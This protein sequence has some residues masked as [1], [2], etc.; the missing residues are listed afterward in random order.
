MAP[1][2]R[3]IESL[4]ERFNASAEVKRAA[5]QNAEKLVIKVMDDLGPT[6]AA[7]ASVAQFFISQGRNFAEVSFCISQVHP[8]MDRLGDLLLE[9]YPETTGEIKLLVG[10]RNRPFKLYSN[11][12]YRKLRIALFASDR[13]SLFELRN[14]R[15]TQAGYDD[16]RVE[17]L[18]P[19]EFRVKADESNFELF[20]VIEEAAFSGKIATWGADRGAL[21]RKYS[22]S[23]LPLTQRL[24]RDAGLLRQAIGEFV[25]VLGQDV[26]D[27]G[28]RSPK[29]LAEEALFEACERVVPPC[30][31]SS[32]PRKYHLRQSSVKSLVVRSELAAWRG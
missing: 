31:S 9:I 4:V 21:M 23:K 26:A 32:I 16:K 24:L 8:A 30:L 12:I 6:K 19:S 15:L 25:R 2:R 17:P 18:G 13:N 7:I 27:S 1:L 14:A 28:G 10:G 22:L 3:E 11:G 20:K 5:K 29:K